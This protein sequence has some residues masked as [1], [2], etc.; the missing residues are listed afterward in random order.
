MGRLPKEGLSEIGALI[1]FQFR[2]RAKQRKRNKTDRVL[3]GN[4]PDSMQEIKTK[5]RLGEERI[6]YTDIEK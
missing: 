5:W 6:G 3:D 4:S 1:Q 2:K